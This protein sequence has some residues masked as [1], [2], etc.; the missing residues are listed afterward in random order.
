MPV[1]LPLA[2]LTL[3]VLLGAVA[4]GQT[5]APGS[6]RGV[7]ES[8]Q[9]IVGGGTSGPQHDAVVQ[10]VRDGFLGCT[11][12]LIAPN[13]VLTA[14]HCVTGDDAQE[15]AGAPE[16]EAGCAL[17]KT[18]PASSFAIKR[19]AAVEPEGRVTRPD[20]RA[21]RV[22]TTTVASVCSFDIAL[23]QLDR[24]VQ[25]A[26]IAKVRFTPLTR[27]ERGLL[28]VGYGVNGRTQD[29]PDA[30]RARGNLVALAIGPA[31]ATFQQRS[32]ETVPY[33]VP[34]NDV[35]TGEST[36]NGDSGGPLFDAQMNVVAVTSRGLP[37]ESTC[38]DLPALYAG[39]AG[40]ADLIRRAAAAAGATLEG[41]RETAPPETDEEEPA[42]DRPGTTSDGRGEGDVAN[43][44]TLDEGDDAASDEETGAPKPRTPKKKTTAVPSEDEDDAR[45]GATVAPLATSGCA[46]SPRSSRG[47]PGLRAFV[48]LAAL[49]AIAAVRRRRTRREARAV[50][51][52]GRPPP[53]PARCTR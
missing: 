21:S 33:D 12:T 15:G 49:A 24:A 40:H 43:E 53:C 4:C 47:G 42:V 41:E 27:G 20:A 17:G 44:A 14:R 16:A 28:A 31:S 46:T 51:S 50:V 52:G 34:A 35:A 23:L 18:L 36:C 9:S 45:D 13:L 38:L 19:G 6:S 30:R 39:V 8:S 10:I 7:S 29:L 26:K 2:A 5:G 22:F 32:G 1:R 37:V 25:G 48:A 3:P 11:G